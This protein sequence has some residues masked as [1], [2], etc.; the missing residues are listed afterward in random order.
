MSW[1]QA[2][3]PNAMSAAVAIRANV[4]RLIPAPF[5]RPPWGLAGNGRY[6]ERAQCLEKTARLVELELRIAS[7][8]AQ[9]ETITAGERETRHVEHRMIGHGEAVQRQHTQHGRQCGDED[10]ALEGDGN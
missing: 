4:G 3:D 2:R 9:K 6:L 10:G 5:S 7:F 1:R 8:D